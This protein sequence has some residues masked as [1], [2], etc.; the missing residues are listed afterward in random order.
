MI[1]FGSGKGAA[2]LPEVPASVRAWVEEKKKIRVIRTVSHPNFSGRIQTARL[3][4][5]Q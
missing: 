1:V 2:K 5:N 4:F 3:C